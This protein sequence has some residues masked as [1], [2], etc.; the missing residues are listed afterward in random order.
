REGTKHLRLV[1]RAYIHAAIGDAEF[2]DGSPLVARLESIQEGNLNVAHDEIRPLA[3]RNA[4]AGLAVHGRQRRTAE[5]AQK[6]RH[7]VKVGGIVL[8]DQDAGGHPRCH[9]ATSSS[10]D[11]LP[12]L[13]RSMRALS[14][15]RVG[16]A[17]LRTNR[18]PQ[19]VMPSALARC[20]AAIHA[21]QDWPTGC[22]W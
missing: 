6:V 12:T 16:I 8:D 10:K 1:F 9:L 4:E 15:S 21:G 7:Q 20:Q 19:T 2:C 3:L 17:P 5:C 18:L 13:E 14:S 22:V 11:T